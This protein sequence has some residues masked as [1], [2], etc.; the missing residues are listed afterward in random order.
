MSLR[1]SL[2][3][4]QLRFPKCKLSIVGGLS[5]TWVLTR[6]PSDH[7]FFF[8]YLQP[9]PKGDVLDLWSN[10][11]EVAQLNSKS[12]PPSPS[13]QTLICF[14]FHPVT[15][16]N[17]FLAALHQTPYLRPKRILLQTGSKHYAFY[18]GP[19]PLPAF[20]SD[21]RVTFAPNFYYAQ[22]DA[23]SA[24]CASIPDCSYTIARPSWI[25]GA[26][27]DG[28]LNHLIAFGIY[29]SVCAYL[30]EPITFPGGYDAWDRE[31][32]Q[33]SATL[34]AYFE[35]FLVLN[36][37][38]KNEAF[39]I[40]DGQS[41]T[42]GRLWPMLAEWYGVVRWEPPSTDESKYRVT[43]LP[44]P[45]T[46]RG[47][48]PQATLRSTFSLLEWS[49][50]P[51]VTTAWATIAQKHKLTLNPFDDAYRARIFSFADA[52]IIGDAPMTLSIRKARQ[53]GFFGTT[54]SYRGIFDT[55]RELE[56]LG[57]IVA[58]THEFV[59]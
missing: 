56:R 48:G 8:S 22:E 18:L 47:Y 24:F 25:I 49:L 51:Q 5:Q 53:F 39:N 30:G 26:V 13:Q 38:T 4:W 3:R 44:Y 46:P 50:K 43:K 7:V 28:S 1:R 12:A 35:E 59:E 37:T 36:D 11:E 16:L 9:A 57:L 45:Q 15:L 27:A 54:D 19:A 52:A 20:E 29:A 14:S 33:S 21:P 58:P 10:A 17:N 2:K 31:M 55:L 23:L 41:F 34:N 32:V 40:H 6:L 42:W